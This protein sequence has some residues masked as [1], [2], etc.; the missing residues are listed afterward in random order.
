M[1]NLERGNTLQRDIRTDG[2]ELHG[3]YRVTY[4]T[5]RSKFSRMFIG[6]YLGRDYTGRILFSQRPA[7]G[8]CILNPEEVE[9]MDRVTPNTPNTAPRMIRVP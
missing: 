3:R 1:S 9:Y 5:V 7:A 6:T 2:L 8:T 4:K